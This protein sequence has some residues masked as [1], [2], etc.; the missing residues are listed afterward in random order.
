M[1]KNGKEDE[2]KW[3]T[4]CDNCIEFL[5]RQEPVACATYN[6]AFAKRLLEIRKSEGEL[7]EKRT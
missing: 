7:K 1:F 5:I 3:C 2:I 4:A 6:K